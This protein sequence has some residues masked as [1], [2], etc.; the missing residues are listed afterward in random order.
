MKLNLRVNKGVK[1]L[2]YNSGFIVMYEGKLIYS[3]KFL[4]GE[5]EVY[6]YYYVLHN[7]IKLGLVRVYFNK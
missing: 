5:T 4:N 6:T 3:Q 2:R 1:L 7:L